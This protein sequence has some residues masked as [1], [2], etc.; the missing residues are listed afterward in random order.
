MPVQGHPPA[1]SG[2][3][4]AAPVPGMQFVTRL[5]SGHIEELWRMYQNEWWSRDRTLHDVRRAVRHSD[6]VF[7]FCDS[8]T[9][10]LVA[11]ARVLTDFVYK[12]LVFDVIVARPHRDLGLGRMLLDAVTSHPAL[13]FV[14][15][16]ELYCR[17]EMVPFY[18][19]WGFTA[20]LPA[21]RFMRKKQEPWL[22]SGSMRHASSS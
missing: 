3:V 7:A 9:G 14:E 6:L 19:K 10:S 5:T 8:E 18:E 15:H 22:A 20:R 21:L 17:D 4:I 1:I 13:L 11:F 12:A 2:P 16:I